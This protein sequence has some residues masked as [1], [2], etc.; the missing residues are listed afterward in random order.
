MQSLWRVACVR[1]PRFPIGAVW[2]AARRGEVGRGTPGADG[3]LLLPAVACRRRSSAVEPSRE[4]RTAVE[5]ARA[6]G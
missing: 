2:R 3:Q 1:I 6:L 5:R 4:L